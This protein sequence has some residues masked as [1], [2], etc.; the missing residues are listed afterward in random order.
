MIANILSKVGG[1]SELTGAFITLFH[2]A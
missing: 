1:Q 2:R